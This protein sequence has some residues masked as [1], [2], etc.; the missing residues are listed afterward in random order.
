MLTVAKRYG[1]LSSIIAFVAYGGWAFWL[2]L[3]AGSEKALA[4]GVIHGIYAATLTYLIYRLIYFF[5]NYFTE[6]VRCP[7]LSTWVSTSFVCFFVPLLIQLS[8]NNLHPLKTIA[9]G[10]IIGQFYI[11]VIL[12]GVKG[13][14]VTRL[15]TLCENAEEN[16]NRRK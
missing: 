8:V 9:P 6:R 16:P 14:P 7:R 15:S 13:N 1:C 4:P 11:L 2:N 12:T 10:F 5:N 3:N